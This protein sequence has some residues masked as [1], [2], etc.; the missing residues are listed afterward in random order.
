MTEIAFGTYTDLGTRRRRHYP[1]SGLVMRDSCRICCRGAE[2]RRRVTVTPCVGNER[3]AD[4]SSA[5]RRTRL[6]GAEI[7]KSL[8]ALKVR[9][10]SHLLA[11]SAAVRNSD[12]DGGDL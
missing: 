12:R 6:E 9:S 2:A 4:T 5:D 10:F 8:L 7:N 11:A 1:Q 3:G